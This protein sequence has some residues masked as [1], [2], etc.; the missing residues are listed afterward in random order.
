MSSFSAAA[1]CRW[2][3][4]SQWQEFR[5]SVLLLWHCF[6][7]GGLPGMLLAFHLDGV[8]FGQACTVQQVGQNN[9]FCPSKYYPVWEEAGRS[10]RLERGSSLPNVRALIKN[11]WEDLIHTNQLILDQVLACWKDHKLNRAWSILIIL[12]GLGRTERS[13]RQAA[14]AVRAARRAGRSAQARCQEGFN[15]PLKWWTRWPSPEVPSSVVLC[16]TCSCCAP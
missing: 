7:Q 1:G 2:G 13:R 12:M 9:S 11:R 14:L 4:L 5:R 6:H 15:W 8:C 16:C 3:I 10:L